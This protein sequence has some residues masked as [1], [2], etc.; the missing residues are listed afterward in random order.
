M[1]FSIRSRFIGIGLI[2]LLGLVVTAGTALWAISQVKVGGPIYRNI[3]LGKDLVADIL[4]PPAYIIEERLVCMQMM[5]GAKSEL[6]GLE[7]RAQQLEKEFADRQAYWREQ[8]P[9]DPALRT[10]ILEDARTAAEECFRLRREVFLPLLRRGKVGEAREVVVGPMRKAYEQHRAAIDRT[11]EM[12]NTFG[13]ACEVE[14]RRTVVLAYAGL[15]VA[16]IGAAMIAGVIIAVTSRST[17]GAVRGTTRVLEA[18]ADG[19]AARRVEATGIPDFDRLGVALNRTIDNLAGSL[20]AVR[21]QVA[22][23]QESARELSAT[24]VEVRSAA[25]SAA[26]Q[27]TGAA[28]AAAGVLTEAKAVAE[29][30]GQLAVGSQ[31]I[32]ARTQEAART[33]AEA[34]TQFAEVQRLMAQLSEASGQIG[35]VTATI[36]ALSEQ[37]NLLALNAT[38]EAAR[39]GDAGRGFAVVASEVKDLARRTASASGE[40]ATRILA[41]QQASTA[42]AA[43]IGLAA[44]AVASIADGQ[45]SV[46]AAVEEQ[47]AATGVISASAERAARSSGEIACAIAGVATAAER[48]KVAAERTGAAAKG[49]QT[50]AIEL[51]A[52]FK[53]G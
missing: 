27:A 7:A 30:T 2:G 10:A 20:Q 24:E 11:V 32:S 19:E 31:E 49:L 3:V 50:L 53:S 21:N 48:S 6:D 4:P 13:A 33:A 43:A 45:Q 22:K 39:A 9:P 42:A 41:V 44:T 26:S 18:M 37:V 46:S 36:T 5:S 52:A 34:R 40:I 51:Q 15:A 12:A 38:I 23:L 1:R 8:L 28:E 25:E 35:A 17:T 14:A 29:N 16:A 47:G